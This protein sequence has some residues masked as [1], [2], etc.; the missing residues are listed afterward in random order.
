MWIKASCTT[1]NSTISPAPALFIHQNLEGQY[2]ICSVSWGWGGG[3]F[4][5]FPS[6]SQLP[7]CTQYQKLIANEQGR[8]HDSISRVRVSRG[9]GQL[10]GKNFN[11][12]TDGRT[13]QW[14]EG[15]TVRHSDLQSGVY[16]W[17]MQPWKPSGNGVESLET[18]R[19]G[20]LTIKSLW[21]CPSIR[22]TCKEPAKKLKEHAKN[23][24]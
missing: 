11:S 12:V 1:M 9:Q 8:I 2:C 6:S 13:N 18:F 7:P 21:V 20:L 24:P 23:Q 17:T 5:I 3:M 15:P 10:S 19:Y 14:T 4:Q 22:L 16:D